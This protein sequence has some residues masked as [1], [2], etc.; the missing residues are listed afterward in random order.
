MLLPFDGEVVGLSLPPLPFVGHRS[1]E[2]SADLR[3]PEVLARA[4]SP[5]LAHG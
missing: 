1:T 3:L 4:R 5:G 2:S